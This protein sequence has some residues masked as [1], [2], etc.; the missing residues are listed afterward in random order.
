MCGIAGIYSFTEQGKDWHSFLSKANQ[1]LALRGPD[2]G[3][4]EFYDHVGLAHRRLSIIDV[5]DAGFQPMK[6]DTGRY[7]LTFN[8]EIYNYKELK[9]PLVDEGFSFNSSTDFEMLLHLYHREGKDFL[10]KLNGFFAF[11][12]FDKVE[13]KLLI[14]RDRV[15]IKPLL[16][17]HDEN[18]FVFASEMKALLEFPIKREID[19]ESLHQYFQLNYIPDNHTILKNVFKLN[20]G[21]FIEIKDN[22]INRGNYYQI[23]RDESN[24]GEFLGGFEQQQS[25]LRELVEDSVKLRLMS[26]VPLGAF[27]SGGIDSS[28]VVSQASKFTDQLN[29]FSIGFQDNEFYDETPY[30]NLVAKKFN[31][32]HTV[33]SLSNNDL[34]ENLNDVLDYLDEPFADSSALLVHILSEQTRKH[35]TVTLSGDGGDEMFAGYNKH[36]A[37]WT[38]RKGG[39]KVNAVKSLNPV[40][41]A[42]PKSRHSKLGNKVRQLYRFSQGMKLSTAERYWRWCLL[43][44]DDELKE[45]IRISVNAKEIK[46]RKKHW[47]K[48]LQNGKGNLNDSLYA[49]MHLVLPGDMLRKVD[50]MSMGNSLEVRVPLLDHRIVEFAFKLPVGSKIDKR[51]NKKILLE[52]F[53]TE[54]PAELYNRPKR[55]FEVPLLQWFKTDLYSKIFDDWLS[56]QWIR[57]QGIFNIEYIQTLKKKNDV[58]QSRRCTSSH[59]G[60][61]SFPKLVSKVYE[62]VYAKSSQNFK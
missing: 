30:A 28:I 38:A 3:R 19:F 1:K 45:L 14:A 55:G 57:E 7:Y 53:K 34:Y 17:Y 54:L 41:N 37:D 32:N 51:L 26:D 43:M 44:P 8:G 22:V 12:I 4:V 11:A 33:F 18:S 27:L 52:A 29:T 50:S 21:E 23:P 25:K 58:K 46:S 61:D 35:V 39:F 9:Q 15:G 10:Q 2:G 36:R 60:T 24:N 42:L 48:F 6:E 16:C 5:S 47:T 40:W 59:L 13:N 56:E 31:T 20:P 62:L 49:D